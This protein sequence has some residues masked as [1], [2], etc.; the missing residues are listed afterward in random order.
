MFMNPALLITFVA[1][2]AKEKEGSVRLQTIDFFLGGHMFHLEQELVWYTDKTPEIRL[3]D[4]PAVEMYTLVSACIRGATVSL[5]SY[6]GEKRLRVEENLL[7]FSSTEYYA[8]DMLV[9]RHYDTNRDGWITHQELQ[10]GN[11]LLRDYIIDYI[12]SSYSP[13]ET[14]DILPLLPVDTLIASVEAYKEQQEQRCIRCEGLPI[15]RRL[16]AIAEYL[17]ATAYPVHGIYVHDFWHGENTL[18]I[19]ASAPFDNTTRFI[20]HA[21]NGRDYIDMPFDGIVDAVTSLEEFEGAVYNPQTG[22]FQ[23][24]TIT[25]STQMMYDVYVDLIHSSLPRRYRV[26]LED[27][28]Q[29]EKTEY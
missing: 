11:A 20:L 23:Q 16:R 28:V 8:A 22:N 9:A 26:T 29:E 15:E 19:Q 13:T 5:S 1:A 4:S 24:Q 27:R 2:F 21:P 12:E 6:L 14:I 3:V 18:R 25:P 10:K 7:P 17:T